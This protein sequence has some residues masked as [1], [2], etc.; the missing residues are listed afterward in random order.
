V[1]NSL[2]HKQKT[3]P[4]AWAGPVEGEGAEKSTGRFS[5]RP[6]KTTV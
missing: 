4:R 2:K 6:E 5:A 3:N 1:S